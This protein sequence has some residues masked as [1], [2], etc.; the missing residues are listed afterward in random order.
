MTLNSSTITASLPS[1]I[2]PAGL[3]SIGL[4]SILSSLDLFVVNLAFPSISR[5]FP[6]QP[7]ATLSLILT[8]FSVCFASTLVL[9]G[10]FADRYG[11][12]TIFS[13]GLALFGLSSLLCGIA[14]TLWILIVARAIQGFAAAMLIPTSLGL[15]LGEYPQE[16]HKQVIGF[17]AATGSVAAAAGP[18]LG[19]FLVQAD[20]HLIFFINVPIV[21]VALICTRYLKE[22]APHTGPAPDITGSVLLTSGI[23]LL[24]TTIAHAPE[25]AAHEAGILTGGVGSIVILTVF[26]YHCLKSSRPL[27]DLSLFQSRAFSTATTGMGCFYMSFA[28]MLLGGTMFLTQA[29]HLTAVQ[30]GLA[31]AAG[32]GTAVV[33]SQLI[34]KVKASPQSLAVA[35]SVLYFLSGLW[36]FLTLSNHTDDAWL[37]HFLP[38]L[39]MTGLGAGIAQTGFMA[40]AVSGLPAQ[41]YSTGTG[42]INTSRQI[43]AAI[44]VAL[45]VALSGKADTPESFRT[46]W[47]L[48]S[49]C[50]L[51]AALAANYLRRKIS[52]KK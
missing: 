45:F 8:I 35:G 43:G 48:M 23:A 18:V 15:L 38:G 49:L 16:K 32:P 50:G 27:L 12:R 20:W 3:L 22:S 2:H 42:L 17:W 46:A 21:I 9:S 30:A 31:F 14:P 7:A 41:M 19:G 36:W 39:V 47:L 25:W 29:W 13:V 34:G 33:A 40:G 51:I 4:G 44:G 11:R 26:V 28:V 6:G 1:R 5:S 24:T 37:L 10:R 52:P